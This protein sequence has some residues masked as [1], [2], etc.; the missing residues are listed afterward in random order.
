[1][2]IERIRPSLKSSTNSR[3]TLL[4]SAFALMVAS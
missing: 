2:F 3:P 1:V 4:R